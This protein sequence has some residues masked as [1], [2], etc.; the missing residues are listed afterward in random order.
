MKT[1]PGVFCCISM[2]SQSFRKPFSAVYLSGAGAIQHFTMLMTRF[3]SLKSNLNVISPVT[4]TTSIK[5]VWNL[6]T[7]LLTSQYAKKDDAQ[8]FLSNPFS[9][10]FIYWDTCLRLKQSWIQIGRHFCRGLALSLDCYENWR[11]NLSMNIKICLTWG[12]RLK[13]L[14]RNKLRTPTPG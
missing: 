10:E 1:L 2:A 3:E 11:S 9:A 6:S 5:F 14:A 12:I 4:S 7:R 13:P 8:S